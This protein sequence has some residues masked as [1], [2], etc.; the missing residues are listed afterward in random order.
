MAPHQLQNVTLDVDG[1]TYTLS[2]DI[3]AICCAEEAVNRPIHEIQAQAAAGS[4]RYLRLLIWAAFQA[5]HPALTIEDVGVLMTRA[6]LPNINSAFGRLAEQMTPD[7]E[8]V[9]ELSP[10]PKAT[11]PVDAGGTGAVSISTPA[12]A[13]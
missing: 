8:T 5:H 7:L 4:L 3:N 10:S 11:G 12:T 9:Q 13:A 1:T 6:G 2:L